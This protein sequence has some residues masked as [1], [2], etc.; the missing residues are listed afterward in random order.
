ML[1]VLSLLQGTLSPRI[2]QEQSIGGSARRHKVQEQILASCTNAEADES[3]RAMRKDIQCPLRVPSAISLPAHRLRPAEAVQWS[4]LNVSR[5]MML[6]GGGASPAAHFL[7]R[8][9]GSISGHE[10]AWAIRADG[11]PR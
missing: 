10:H 11:A 6:T 2:T 4:K 7:W 8:H 3:E 9:R 5:E 1:V